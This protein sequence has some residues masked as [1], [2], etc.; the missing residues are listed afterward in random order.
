[1]PPTPPVPTSPTISCPGSLT[2]TSVDGLAVAVTYP[3][4]TVVGGAT[5]VSTACAPASASGFPVGS[6]AVMCIATDALNRTAS[7][8]FNVVVT[9]PPRLSATQFV[10]F[11][12]SISDGV[13]GLRAVGDAG[14]A[15]GYAFKLRR[16]LADRYTAQTIVMTDEGVPGEDVTT[17]RL[18]LP[19]VLGRDLPQAV[20]LLEGVND[21]NG[22]GQVAI[23]SV[24]DNLRTMVREVRGRGMAAFLATL[25]PQRPGGFRAHAVELIPP[26][27]ARIRE[28]AAEEGA[29]LVDL[30]AAFDGQTATLLGADGLHP[31]DAG[32]QRMAEVFFE[33]IRAQLEIK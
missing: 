14:P 16:L 32:Y 6:T 23:R 22:K 26:T 3:D 20:M 9:G 11:G 17:G 27:N 1:M 4:A 2:G 12:D 24:V 21:L 8:T 15:V 25:L 33:A 30:Y 29:V 18:R 5:P 10:A 13:L 31:N 28:M 7:C 19:I